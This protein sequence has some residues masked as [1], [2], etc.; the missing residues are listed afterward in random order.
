MGKPDMIFGG[1]G[2]DWFRFGNMLVN[3]SKEGW[4]S[5]LW[6]ATVDFGEDR[7]VVFTENTFFS[8]AAKTLSS[9]DNAK[10]KTGFTI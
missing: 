10:Y 2:K 9:N 1:S 4:D 5:V 6:S 7:N 3:N 8:Y